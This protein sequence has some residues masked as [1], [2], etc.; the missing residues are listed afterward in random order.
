MIHLLAPMFGTE[1][2]PSGLSL[3]MKRIAM[4]LRTT[5]TKERKIVKPRILSNAAQEEAFFVG[6]V[7][8]MLLMVMIHRMSITIVSTFNM[9]IYD[10]RI[11]Y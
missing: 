1:D 4:A 7:D 11:S 9:I 2:L 5:F 3:Q 10:K 8:Q 6:L